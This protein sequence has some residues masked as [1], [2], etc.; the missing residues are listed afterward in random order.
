MQLSSETVLQIITG[1]RSD[2]S[3]VGAREARKS[4][5][6]GVRGRSSIVVPA[7]TGNRQH[8]VNVRDLSATG[9]GL[10]IA[11]PLVA[12]GDDFLLLLSS[13]GQ[14]NS[15][16]MRCKVARVVKLSQAIYAVGATFQGDTL[17]DLTPSAPA[18]PPPAKAAPAKPVAMQQVTQDLLA[19]A[20]QNTVDEL[21]QRLRR[22]SA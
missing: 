16:A 15:R 22:L 11:E 8:Q 21:E 5:R 17:V 10:L 13:N 4:P 1:L 18:V 7:R 9:I 6:V 19:Q 12:V 14:D 2:V 3:V 20:D